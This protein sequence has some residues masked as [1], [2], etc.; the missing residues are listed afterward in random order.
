VQS[1]YMRRWPVIKSGLIFGA[2]T[3][4]LVL[5]SALITPLCAPCL[6]LFLGLAAGYFAG[7]FDKPINAGDCVKKGGIAGGIAGGLGLVGVLIGGVIYGTRLDP[8]SLEAT[9]RALGITN[10]TINQTTIWKYVVLD[11][12]C[13]G[14]FT[15]VWMAM[16]GVAG[17][18]I[19]YQISGKNKIGMMLPPQPPMQPG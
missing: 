16:L 11:T 18:V 2:I 19:W 9:F 10:F 5:G 3:F 7:V 4:V 13:I 17:G 8:A 6:G 14:L 1:S 15:V 12:V